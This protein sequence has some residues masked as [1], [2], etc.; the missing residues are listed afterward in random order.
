[1]PKKVLPR[2]EPR[3][4]FKRTVDDFLFLVEWLLHFEFR[5]RTGVEMKKDFRRLGLR[6]PRP[7]RGRETGFVITINGLTVVIWSTFDE[8]LGKWR[9]KGK[10][11]MWSL[12]LDGDKKKYTCPV[13]R[14]KYC[15]QTI[16]NLAWIAKQRILNRPVCPHCYNL[17][18][19]IIKR[20][21]HG[22]EEIKGVTYS[23]FWGCI[24]K[25]YK[26]EPVFIDWDHG[27]TEKAKKFEEKRRAQRRRY[28]KKRE[29]EGKSFGQARER[30]KPWIITRPENV[31]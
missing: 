14:T 6:A 27:L 7:I 30:R 18:N 8:K 10:D 29:K 1:M 20:H 25:S 17:L 5:K 11:Q 2:Y 26:D 12:I 24:D 28:R 15:L 23:Y 3:R 4:E 13:R 31:K 16:I 19:I 9:P 21:E 22:E